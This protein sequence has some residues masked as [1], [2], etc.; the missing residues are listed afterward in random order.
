MI[1][2]ATMRDP[3]EQVAWVHRSYEVV[4]DWLLAREF[5]PGRRWSTASLTQLHQFRRASLFTVA[6]HQS[7]STGR[8]AFVPGAGSRRASGFQLFFVLL[9]GLALT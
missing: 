4:D 6:L 7:T 2:N 3:E 1:Q 9:A 8:S 5:I